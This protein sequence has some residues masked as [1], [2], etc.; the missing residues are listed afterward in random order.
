M[1]P[2]EQMSLHRHRESD[3]NRNNEYLTPGL[4]N[5][6]SGGQECSR[7]GARRC[8][9][10]PYPDAG[11]QRPRLSI[12]K[13]V[14]K[15]GARSRDYRDTSEPSVQRPGFAHSSNVM[16]SGADR[17]PLHLKLECLARP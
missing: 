5:V 12:Y 11:R 6:K 4:L 3:G 14:D 13:P 10:K 1:G 8:T 17:R 16:V 2:S 9:A 15:N 7:K